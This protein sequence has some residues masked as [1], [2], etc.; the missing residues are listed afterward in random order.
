MKESYDILQ[1]EN[2][3]RFVIDG[4]DE[5]LSKILEI[6]SSDEKSSPLPM[7]NLKNLY[8]TILLT[9]KKKLKML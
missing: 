7:K 8:G 4:D 6:K 1:M 3:N 2:W 9:D 5:A